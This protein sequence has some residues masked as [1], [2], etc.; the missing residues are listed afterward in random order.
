MGGGEGK[1]F[2]GP[3]S[4]FQFVNQLGASIYPG[5]RNHPE[6]AIELGGLFL[7]A[8][9]LCDLQQ[10]VSGG[11]GAVAPEFLSV[12]SSEGEGIRQIPQQSSAYGRAIEMHDSNEPAHRGTNGDR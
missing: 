2:R 12:R 7:R 8:T 9:F 11:N 1:G 5:I 10:F 3:A 6:A 4:G